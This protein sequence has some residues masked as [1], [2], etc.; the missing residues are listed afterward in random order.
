MRGAPLLLVLTGLF[1]CA[2]GLSRS[3]EQ[4]TGNYSQTPAIAPDGTLIT[5]D[6]DTFGGDISFK[7]LD[8][9]D[10]A[11]IWTTGHDWGD[12]RPKSLDADGNLIVNG[13][14]RVFG[15]DPADGSEVWSVDEPGVGWLQAVDGDRIY[16]A[17][18]DQGATTDH[19]LVAIDREQVLWTAPL[20]QLLGGIAVGQDGTVYG[21]G[22]RLTAWDSD[23]AVLWDVELSGVGA[24]V[25]L[26]PGK[27]VTAMQGLGIA[28]FDRAD[29]S[30]L[31]VSEVA[32]DWEPAIAADGTIYT[33]GGAGLA[34]L[35]GE[36]GDLLWEAALN[37]QPP[38]LGGDGRL[39]GMA[40][41]LEDEELPDLGSKMHFVVLS[42]SDGEVLWKEWQNESVEALNHAPSFDGGRVYFGAGYTLAHVYAFGGGP[43]LG[44]GPWPRTGGDNGYRYK[45][46]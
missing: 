26:A 28:A 3:W 24:Y 37:A 20:T 39:Y 40:M 4:N 41:M 44:S 9:S 14:D 21:V 10:G 36:T 38:A 17:R 1:G 22:S 27:V 12:T 11:T 45:E 30:Q 29:G 15:L 35:D 5:Y 19:E 6:Y 33:Q 46:Q 34:A 23:G 18:Q 16:L 31:W 13:R 8:P 7:G 42:T 25:A 43:V 2:P 32:G